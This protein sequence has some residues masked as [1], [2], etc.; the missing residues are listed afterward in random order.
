M[1]WESNITIRCPVEVVFA[2]VTDPR[3]GSKWHRSQE[4]KPMSDDSIGVG[5]KYLITGRFLVWRFNSIS[6]VSEYEANRVVSYR[7]Q[8]GPYPFELRYIFEPVEAGT[9]L[10]EIGQASLKGLLKVAVRLF[11]GPAKRNSERGLHLLQDILE[12]K[13]R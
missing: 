2:F 7:S 1:K 4:I 5:A 12:N 9:R 13:A 3:N 6:E 11:V 8:S 10:T